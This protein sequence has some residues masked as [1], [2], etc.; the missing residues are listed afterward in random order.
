[1]SSQEARA[2]STHGPSDS[3]SKNKLEKLNSASPQDGRMCM[4]S[5]AGTWVTT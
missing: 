1:M 2:V 3:H 4:I 5:L